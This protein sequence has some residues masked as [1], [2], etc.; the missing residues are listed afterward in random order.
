MS[1][2]SRGKLVDRRSFLEGTMVAAAATALAG[3]FPGHLMAAEA[4]ELRILFAGGS[5]KEWYEQTFVSPFAEKRGTKLLWKTGLN[6]DPLIIA[7]RA[8]PQWDLVHLNQNTASQLGA[9]NTLIEWK[10]QRIPNM[11]KIHPAFRYQ[12]LVGKTH[13]PYGIAVNTKRIKKPIT[14]WWDLW[15]PE[16]AG[17]VAFPDWTWVGQEVFHA[18]NLMAGGDSENIDPGIAKMKDLFKN[19]RA[20]IINNVEHTKPLLVAEEVWICPYFGARTEQAKEAG[21]PVEFLIPKEGGL[22]WIWNTGIVSGRPK[23][24]IELAERLMNDTLDAEKQIAF[25]R[26]TGY[27]PTNLDAIKNLPPDL[28][29]LEFSDAALEG[30]NKLQRKFDYMGQF[31]YRDRNR[32]RWNKEVLGS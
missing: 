30:L 2:E 4:K 31:A 22:S 12:Y 6:F 21:A 8:R 29:K 7:Q 9:L 32:E 11:K 24:S 16:F 26:K 13:T 3:S 18:I 1:N 28:K 14:S 27:P 5:W 20:S 15:D 25:C 10:P 23:E 17:K 19:S